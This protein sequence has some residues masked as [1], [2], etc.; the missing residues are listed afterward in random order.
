MSDLP[1]TALQ[2]ETVTAAFALRYLPEGD[3]WRAEGIELTL[4]SGGSIM[5]WNETDWTLKVSD[6][7]WPELPDWAW[8]PEAW[9]FEPIDGLGRPGLDE[10]LTASPVHNEVGEL[11]GATLGFPHGTLTVGSGD[12]ISWTLVRKD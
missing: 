3:E 9:V 11:Y 12:F 6:G 4:A 8:P 5:L 7:G 1:T 2:G 10:I